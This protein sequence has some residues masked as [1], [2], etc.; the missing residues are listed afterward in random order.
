MFCKHC[1]KDFFITILVLFFSLGSASCAEKKCKSDDDCD[2]GSAC[3]NGECLSIDGR[4]SLRSPKRKKPNPKKV[5]RIDVDPKK[6]PT[7]GPDDALVTIVEISEF[8]CPYCKRGAE[9][10]KKLVEKYPKDVRLVFM[11]N[12]LGFHKNAMGAAQAA[13]AVF[14][15]KGKEAFW[16]FHDKA[17]ESQKGGLAPGDLERYAR[18]I[19]VDMKKFKKAMENKK[20]EREIKRQMAIAGKFG[21]TGVPGFFINGRFLGG[22]QPANKIE[23]LIKEE[24]EKAKK[25]VQEKR[26]SRDKVYQH[27]MKKAKQSL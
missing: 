17:F 3:V 23:K 2:K 4:G 19:G 15:I 26:V 10:V 6:H 13:Q 9:T 25:L 24:L 7:M 12:P 14:H 5:Y 18:E 21:V 16:K 1:R 11:H 8:E 27:I 20:Y 22:A